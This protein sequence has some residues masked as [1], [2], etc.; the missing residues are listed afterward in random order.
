MCDKKQTV[1]AMIHTFRSPSLFTPRTHRNR[2]SYQTR[3]QL[4]LELLGY[5]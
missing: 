1:Q 3:E 2:D 4:R 5:S